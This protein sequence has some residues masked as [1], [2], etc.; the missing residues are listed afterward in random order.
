MIC[1]Q[2]DSN[3]ALSNGPRIEMMRF[4][5]VIAYLLQKTNLFIFNNSEI[6]E[7]CDTLYET[8]MK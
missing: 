1:L 8:T 2:V 3:S 5:N 7:C 6:F 4:Y